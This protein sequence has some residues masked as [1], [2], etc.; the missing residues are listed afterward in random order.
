MKI[1]RQPSRIVKLRKPI[2]ITTNKD[3]RTREYLAEGEIDKLCKTIR[4][5][6]N[7]PDRDECIV[8]TMFRHALR[9]GETVALKWSQVDFKGGLLH[10]N[11]LKGS[12]GGTHPIPGVE[13]RLLRKLYRKDNKTSHIFMSERKAPMTTQAIY[14]MLRNIEKRAGFD[15]PIHP[16]M[17]RHS[18]G[19]YL[20]NKGVDTRAIQ[21]YMGHA[22]ISN[23]VIYTQLTSDRFQDF[24]QD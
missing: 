7:Y 19:F 8:L 17:L 22:N 20:A 12:L 5:C 18:C 6:S 3:V 14:R 11:R 16:H 23:T 9:I 10:V 13:L 21:L 1:E 4:Q 2:R 24:W 15:F